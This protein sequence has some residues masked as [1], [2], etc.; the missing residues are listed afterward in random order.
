MCKW[1]WSRRGLIP[2]QHED[3]PTKLPFM[4]FLSNG[5]SFPPDAENRARGKSEKTTGR[6]RSLPLW[7]R[8]YMLCEPRSDLHTDERNQASAPQSAEQGGNERPELIPQW[9][10]RSYGLGGQGDLF[11]IPVV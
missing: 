6:E 2:N 8:I 1:W 3:Q 4:L 5:K 10:E 7:I 9:A 11:W